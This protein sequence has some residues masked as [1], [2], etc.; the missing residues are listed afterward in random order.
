M[1][2]EPWEFIEKAILGKVDSEGLVG[3]KVLVVTGMGGCG[4]TQIVLKF[5]EVHRDK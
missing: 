5:M 1:R 4:K 2:R 3:P